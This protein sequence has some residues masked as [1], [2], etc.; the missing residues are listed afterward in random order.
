MEIAVL[1][2][3][4]SCE[5][6]GSSLAGLVIITA[7]LQIAI[8][9]VIM[10]SVIKAVIQPPL[11]TTDEPTSKWK[12]PSASLIFGIKTAISLSV[13]L[14]PLQAPF[15]L[16][17]VYV[18]CER[19]QWRPLWE[20]M[21][22]MVRAIQGPWVISRDFNSVVEVV[23]RSQRT[24]DLG[25]SREFVEAINNAGL[26]DAGF[27]RSC[28]TWCNNQHGPARVW[29][30][31]DRILMNGLWNSSFPN[32]QVEHLSRSNFD[33]APLLLVLPK[34]TF[35]GPKPFHFQRLW[36]LYESFQ[37]AVQKAW[38]SKSL[39]DPMVNLL[40]KLQKV[41]NSLKV[42]KKEVFG[43]IFVQVKEAKST[44]EDIEEKLLSIHDSPMDES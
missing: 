33:H 37:L 31:L 20:E 44:V 22:A 35:V 3:S 10:L 29:A 21:A 9:I 1:S 32:F 43:D 34:Q 38:E 14:P 26:L 17:F 6:N 5:I 16:L 2:A 18:K 8:R 11:F 19:I 42:W 24:Q 36:L 4:L 7:T 23:E 30:R 28:F 25:S 39:L 13:T 41:K 27:F 12:M 40:V 15:I